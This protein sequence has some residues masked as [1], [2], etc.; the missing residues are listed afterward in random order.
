M[1]AHWICKELAPEQIVFLTNR[2][3]MNKDLDLVIMNN[4]HQTKCGKDCILIFL[5]CS[6]FEIDIEIHDFI[7]NQFLP[8]QNLQSKSNE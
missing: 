7:L 1:F 4:I 8:L 3:D 5:G 2:D 6:E